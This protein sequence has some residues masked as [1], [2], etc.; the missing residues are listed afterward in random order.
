MCMRVGQYVCLWVIACVLAMYFIIIP[1]VICAVR[2]AEFPSD[3]RS[4]V[5]DAQCLQGMPKSLGDAIFPSEVH[6]GYQ[7]PIITGV[8]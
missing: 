1:V 6:S 2:I 5:P 8:T 4:E 3:V 7:I